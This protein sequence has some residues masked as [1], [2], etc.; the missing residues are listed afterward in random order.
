MTSTGH[1]DE[2]EVTP[3]DQFRDSAEFLDVLSR[4][5]WEALREPV[6]AALQ[7]IA[8]DAGT[9]LVDLGAGTGL[10]TLVLASAAPLADVIAVEPSTALRAITLARVA[11]DAE[12]SR[13]VT[14]V[15]GRAEDTDL[16]AHAGAI[17]AMNMIGHLE[18]GDRRSLWDR[19]RRSLRPGAPLVVNTQPPAEPVPVPDTGFS[20]VT[21]GRLTY[22]GSGSAEPSGPESVRWRMRYRVE[23]P[24]GTTLRELTV[25]YD[26]YVVSPSALR[27][28]LQAAGFQ[29]VVMDHGVVR[30]VCSPREL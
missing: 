23:D 24:T 4:P 25:A 14:V 21:V 6:L 7:G 2:H 5:A 9:T 17:L 11:A 15:P 12:L 10:G 18:L 22:L 13:R 27:H 1:A 19:A 26:W 3:R 8:P 28:E 16:P 20:G 29:V 30:A